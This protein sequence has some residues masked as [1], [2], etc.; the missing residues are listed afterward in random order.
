MVTP[1]RTGWR[2]LYYVWSWRSRYWWM[3]TRGGRIA[4]LVVAA[5]F[6]LLF[7]LLCLDKMVHPAPPD[8]PQKAIVW[9]VQLI[10][11]VVAAL[12][13]YAMAPKPKPPEAQQFKAPVTQDGTFLRRH[14]GT[15]WMDDSFIAAC[16]QMGTDKIRKKGGK[17]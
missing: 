10:I 1:P 4:N 12:V 13:S 8:E 16:K 6:A 3:D 11:M 5:A 17:K 2:R 14:Y 9:W 7:V 15:C